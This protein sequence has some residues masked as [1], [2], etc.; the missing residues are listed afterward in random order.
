LQ[1]ILRR[2]SLAEPQSMS[3]STFRASFSTTMTLCKR[4]MV[5]S[6]CQTRAKA[7]NVAKAERANRKP[8]FLHCE[9]LD[10]AAAVRSKPWRP[11]TNGITKET[12]LLVLWTTFFFLSIRLHKASSLLPQSFNARLS[13]GDRK[14]SIKLSISLRASFIYSPLLTGLRFQIDSRI[15]AR[16]T[17]PVSVSGLLWMPIDMALWMSMS[18]SS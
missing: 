18:I 6:L 3:R 17:S 16:D 5:T 1:G 4:L 14:I 10:S 11:L 7:Q 15:G 8:R 12:S 2:G 13:S 9:E